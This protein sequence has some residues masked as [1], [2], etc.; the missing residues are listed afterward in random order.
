[1]T[2]LEKKYQKMQTKLQDEFE[3][4]GLRLTTSQRHGFVVTV[5]KKT[6]FGQLDRSDKFV[7]LSETISGRTWMYNV[8]HHVLHC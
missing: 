3:A 5:K 8:S 7:A 1:M 6:E 2:R 4:P